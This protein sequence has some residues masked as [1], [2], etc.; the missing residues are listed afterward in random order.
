[1]SAVH[2]LP[3]LGPLSDS[4]PSGDVDALTWI[5]VFAEIVGAAVLGAVGLVQLRANDYQL[6]PVAP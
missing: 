3:D 5:A 2:L 6:R 1:M 4:L